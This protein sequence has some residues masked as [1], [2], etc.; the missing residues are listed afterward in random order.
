MPTNHGIYRKLP[1]N[2]LPGKNLTADEVMSFRYGI[3]QIFE[4]LAQ[5]P[6]LSAT[7]ERM[8]AAQL[9]Y[10]F[11]G[12][13]QRFVFGL[14]HLNMLMQNMAKAYD[15][16]RMAIETMALKL[17]AEYHADHILTYLNTFVDDIA[18]VV[19]LATGVASKRP[20]DSMSG[21]KAAAAD[22]TLA[23]VAALL[24][25]LDTTGSWWELAF[26]PKVGGRQLIVHNQHLVTMHGSSSLGCQFQAQAA[27]SSPPAQTPVTGDFLA[28]LRAVFG[29][30]FEWLDRLQAALTSQLLAK[31]SAWSPTSRCHT[32]FLPVG[33]PP[34]LTVYH[35]DYFPLPVCEGSDPLPWSVDVAWP[36]A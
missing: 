9:E 32:L 20:I 36:P 14:Q 35:P 13:C 8:R 18:N 1:K 29:G 34:G 12:L 28:L 21:L 31:S 23:P 30:L 33:H 2:P 3:H 7:G 25:E 27:L 10:H 24:T 11:R 26:K 4:A 16:E 15:Q 6:F 5:G 22:P 17:D 19:V